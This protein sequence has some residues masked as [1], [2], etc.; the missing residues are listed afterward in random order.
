MP[1]RSYKNSRSQL[2]RSRNTRHRYTNTQKINT[3]QHW[4]GRRTVS[5]RR[6]FFWG[7]GR[8]KRMMIGGDGENTGDGSQNRKQCMLARKILTAKATALKTGICMYT[9]KNIK[10][11][12]KIVN[13]NFDT[14]CQNYDKFTSLMMTGKSENQFTQSH[15][16]WGSYADEYKQL[17]T[18]IKTTFPPFSPDV[19][20]MIKQYKRD[21]NKLNPG[22]LCLNI[23]Q[24][25]RTGYNA[26][27][28]FDDYGDTTNVQPLSKG[29]IEYYNNNTE[30]THFQ[31]RFKDLMDDPDQLMDEIKKITDSPDLTP[32]TAH[33]PL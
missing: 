10:W 25:L 14:C 9:T 32:P 5:R 12:F 27:Y 21:N 15:K 29:L 1:R 13:T 7:G 2:T 20:Q 23:N 28:S 26:H 19:I 33:Q 17:I 16:L 6:A 18:R 24:I 31:K 4:G 11:A 30:Q 8:K 22:N 3:R